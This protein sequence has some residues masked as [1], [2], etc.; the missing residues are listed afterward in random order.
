MSRNTNLQLLKALS[1]ETRYRIVEV[2]LGGEKCACEIPA[3]I[4]STQSNTSMHLT[5]MVDLGIL[6]SRREGK[7]IH[8]SIAN[9][10]ICSLFKALGYSD[11]ALSKTCCCMEDKR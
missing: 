8:Y 1:V 6:T 10:V 11:K 7:K 2:L 5:K 9:P 3:L 4:K